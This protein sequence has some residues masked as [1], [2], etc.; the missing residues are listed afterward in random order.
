[1]VAR[2]DTARYRLGRFVNRNKVTVGAAA[3]VTVA[4]VGATGWSTWQS[5]RRAAALQV[6]QAERTRAN[7]ITNFLLGVFRATN[8][9]ET[10]G[11]TV[12][13]RELL[14]QAAA[15]VAVDLAQEPAAR[16]DMELA[17]GQAYSFIGV[18]ATAE[19]LFA[20]VAEPR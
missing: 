6:A 10:R 17:I 9:S 14:D 15:R 3:L 4:L 8:P 18:L 7:R 20:H 12:T 19:S 2:P 16:A 5:A 13:A 11:R 1:V